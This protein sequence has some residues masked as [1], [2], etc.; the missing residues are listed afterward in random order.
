MEV[1]S[2]VSPEVFGG[3][4]TLRHLPRVDLMHVRVG[5]VF[6]TADHFRVEQL[7]FLG[8][9]LDALVA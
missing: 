4:I 1:G 9:F 3:H 8:E 6:H 7:A 5:R 2:L